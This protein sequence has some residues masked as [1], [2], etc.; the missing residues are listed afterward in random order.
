MI[1]AYLRASTKEQDANR[2]KQSLIK[3]VSKFDDQKIAAFY[4]ENASGTK[5]H[6]PELMR[7]IDESTHGDIL[8]VESMDR[9]SRLSS[10][11]WDDLKV[12]LSKKK[13]MIVVVDMPSTHIQMNGAYDS[14]IM[15]IFNNMFLDLYAEFA[16]R[17]WERRRE[18]TRQGIEKAKRHGKFKG[19]PADQSKHNLVKALLKKG[20]TI[21]EVAQ[22]VGYTERHVQNLKN[23]YSEETNKEEK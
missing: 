23:K 16:Y 2:A 12:I 5:L 14:R 3:F 19:K 1:K 22:L 15:E 18:V 10:N 8:L 20:H 17:D 4:I 11:D 7:L 9:L 21:K 6:R 13:I